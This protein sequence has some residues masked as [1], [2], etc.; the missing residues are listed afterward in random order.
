MFCPKCGNEMPSYAKKCRVCGAEK[1]SATS[2]NNDSKKTNGCLLAIGIAIAFVVGMIFFCMA[3]CSPLVGGDAG[4]I[5]Q[6]VGL[7]AFFVAGI[8]ITA[9]KKN[10]GLLKMIAVIAAMYYVVWFLAT[11]NIPEF[12]RAIPG[13]DFLS[14][15][16][17]YIII[18]YAVA[19]VAMLIVTK[20]IAFSHKTELVGLQYIDGDLM[21][22][23]GDN[24][25]KMSGYY[26]MKAKLHG[27]VIC[28]HMDEED[29]AAG[30]TVV[31]INS[32]ISEDELEDYCQQNPQ[33][34]KIVAYLQQKAS[35]EE[36][37]TVADIIHDVTPRP[38]IQSAGGI[39][40]AKVMKKTHKWIKMLTFAA[41]SLAYYLGITKLLMGMHNEKEVTNLVFGGFI[42]SFILLAIFLVVRHKVVLPKISGFTTN[43]IL[44]LR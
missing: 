28:T 20:S 18:V 32:A 27:I 35:E 12:I 8:I 42:V 24:R 11:K 4:T 25:Y 39:A 31:T 23:Q 5:M 30:K 26:L 6:V 1:Q 43:M 10:Y 44:V 34:A 15:W 21:I 17:L 37:V 33:V 13:S 2:T 3:L 22:L 29:D 14:V 16:W 9:K 36:E 38:V 41:I 40:A 19:V 7:T